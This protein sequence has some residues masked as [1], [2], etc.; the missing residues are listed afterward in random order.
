MSVG[1]LNHP[2]KLLTGKSNVIA[3]DFEAAR[4]EEALLQTVAA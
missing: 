4:E 2:A 1:L 3:V